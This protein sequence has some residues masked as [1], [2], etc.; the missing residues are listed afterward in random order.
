MV[1][2]EDFEGFEVLSVFVPGAEAELVDVEEVSDFGVGRDKMGGVVFVREAEV[3]IEPC[4]SFAGE[5]GDGAW[6]FV[7]RAKIVE[8]EFDRRMKGFEWPG[9]GGCA[10]HVE[11]SERVVGEVGVSPDP[12]F[13]AAMEGRLNTIAAED[14]AFLPVEMF[15]E[16]LAF[17]EESGS[18]ESAEALC[19]D[20][21]VD[22][23]LM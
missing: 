3:A 14:S 1:F 5:F 12:E 6:A 7:G 15:A 2:P 22:F 8:R 21:A 19:N 9:R 13:F 11:D 17:G 10:G 16:L 23:D 20:G 18:G 4:G